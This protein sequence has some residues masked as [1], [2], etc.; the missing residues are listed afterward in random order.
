MRVLTVSIAGTKKTAGTAK[1]KGKKKLMDTN[2]DEIVLSEDDTDED[3]EDEALLKTKA[4]GKR[5]NRAAVLRFALSFTFVVS[6]INCFLQ[7]Q[8]ATTKKAPA[9]KTA[10]RT[11]PKPAAQ[12]QSQTQLTFAPAGRS[13]RTAA[14]QARRKMVV[15]TSI[16][17]R[18]SAC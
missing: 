4:P 15:S 5:T 17:I 6:M 14:T 13:S 9:K 2:E 10:S 8:P 18:L 11:K 1:G 3:D 7:S 12:T 16:L